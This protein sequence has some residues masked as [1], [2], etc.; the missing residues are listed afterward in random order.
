MFSRKYSSVCIL[1]TSCLMLSFAPA[2]AGKFDAGAFLSLAWPQG[3]FSNEVDFAWGGGARVGVNLMPV[4]PLSPI[5][6]VDVNYLNY[7]SD[8]RTVPFSITVPNVWVDV[9]TSNYMV[10]VSPGLQV[11]LRRGP[12][13]PYG[14]I[15]AGFTYIA[16]R[17]SVSNDGFSGEEIASSTNFDDW[18]WNF[19]V[20][21]G[22]QIPVWIAPTG[23]NK[24]PGVGEV[25]IDINAKYIMSGEAEYLKEGSLD[26]Y[27]RMI[28]YNTDTNIFQT[29]I[30]VT[31]SF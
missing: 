20:G 1:L 15:S 26:D 16:T 28:T 31:V 27:G 3:D 14:E 24:V 29:R 25:M 18:T 4:A 8:S 21:G 10:M 2:K 5:L 22:L 11:G 13:R 19:G 6:F 7:G 12:V 30:G 9:N 17:T 23:V